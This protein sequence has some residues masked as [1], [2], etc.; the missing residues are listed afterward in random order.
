MFF[1]CSVYSASINTAAYKTMQAQ[2]YRNNYNKQI[3]NKTMPYW[4]VQSNFSTR[5][6]YSD[7]A[8]YTNA[9]N[10]YNSTTRTYRSSQ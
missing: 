2:S 3:S 10:Q 6:R 9:I 4:Q 7:Y 1:T 5:N 8:N